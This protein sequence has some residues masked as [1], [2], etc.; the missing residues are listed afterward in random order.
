LG[1]RKAAKQA[2]MEANR[3]EPRDLFSLEE[4]AKISFELKQYNEAIRYCRL[5]WKEDVSNPAVY[6]L[7][8]FS[9]Y[10]MDDYELALIFV[11]EGLVRFPNNNTLKELLVDLQRRTP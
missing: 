4:I 7:A 1:N 5:Y 8:A 11:E 9:S 3:L 6:E 10:Y 2:L